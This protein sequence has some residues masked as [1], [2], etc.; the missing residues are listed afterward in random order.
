[1][2]LIRRNIPEISAL[3]LT[4]NI[5]L[6]YRSCGKQSAIFCHSSQS[7]YGVYE[8]QISCMNATF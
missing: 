1:M 7:H 8:T 5:L 4:K 2:G 3:F 6:F